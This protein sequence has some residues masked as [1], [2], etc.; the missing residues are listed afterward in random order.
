M[1][2][3]DELVVEELLDKVFVEDVTELVPVVDAVS[4]PELLVVVVEDA[5]VEEAVSK[6]EESVSLELEVELEDAGFCERAT[7][8]PAVLATVSVTEIGSPSLT[9]SVGKV[10]HV[11]AVARACAPKAKMCAR[12]R[13]RQAVLMVKAGF[14]VSVAIVC[15]R[16]LLPLLLCQDA[17]LPFWNISWT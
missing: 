4:L 1:I 14:Q 5:A 9:C 11:A 6:A 15:C 7:E 16:A 12:R 10:F 2:V 17:I 3:L 8:E 13:S